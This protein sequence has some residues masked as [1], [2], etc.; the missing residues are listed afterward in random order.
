VARALSSHA[1]SRDPVQ[2]VVNE[3]NQLVERA[4]VALSPSKQQAGDLRGVVANPDILG[5][6]KDLAA[7]LAIPAGEAS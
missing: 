3:R 2:L 6:F 5:L 4:L 7:V 1:S